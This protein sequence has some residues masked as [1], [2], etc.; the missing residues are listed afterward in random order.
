[1]SSFFEVLKTGTLIGKYLTG[2]ETEKE[3]KLL[4][5]WIDE[6]EEKKTLFDSIRDEKQLVNSVK[7]YDQFSPDVAWKRYSQSSTKQSRKEM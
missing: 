7:E 4:H 5:E 3:Q 1:M 2:K 6:K